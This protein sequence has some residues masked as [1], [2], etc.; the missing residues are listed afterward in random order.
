MAIRRSYA[1]LRRNALNFWPSALAERE[2]EASVIPRLIESQD[3]FISLLHVADSSPDCWKSIL[4]QTTNFPAN[5]FLKHLMVLTDMGGEPLKRLKTQLPA[6]FPDG[7]MAFMWRDAEHAYRFT[8]LHATAQWDNKNL[9]VDGKGLLAPSDL[10]PAIE[11]VAML[12]LYGG[13]ATS[14]NLPDF[15]AD[16]CMVGTLLGSKAQLDTFVR[17]RYI[18]VSRITGGAT[19][20]ALGHLAQAYVKETLQT[21]LPDWDFSKNAISGISQTGGRTDI[22]FDMIAESPSA[23]YCA[24][25]VSFQV[26]TNSVIERKAGQAKGRHAILRRNGH[27]I[28]YVIDGAGNFER[29]SALNTICKYSDCAVTFKDC[30]LEALARFLAQVGV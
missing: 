11:D 8:S 3:K 2:Q 21:L 19:A 30:E 29:E 18:W 28:A 5:L 14:P 26:T 10:M 13:S 12:L 17:Q 20:N 15:V 22:A 27:H 9:H 16:K 25:E 7:Q 24:I 1:D 6:V 4:A 23:K